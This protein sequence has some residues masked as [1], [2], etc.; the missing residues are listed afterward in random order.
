MK[1]YALIPRSIAQKKPPH[2]QPCNRCGLC[3]MMTLCPLAQHVFGR[4]LG[5]CPALERDADGTASCGL[6]ADPGKH[7]LGYTL[8]AG[9]REAASDAAKLLIGAGIGCDARI[10]GEEP[11]RA[12]Y[13]RAEQW[14]YE[15]RKAI[16]K[17]RKA[18]GM[19]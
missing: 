3:C 17:A 16:A 8:R 10:N 19:K 9:G 4:E 11:D 12:F 7:A 1:P 13:L 15:N 18:W 6:I 5:P 14:D 2:G